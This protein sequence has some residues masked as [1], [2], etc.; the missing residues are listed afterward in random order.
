MV[1]SRRKIGFIAEDALGG[2]ISAIKGIVSLLDK[3]KYECHVAL[4]NYS[5]RKDMTTAEP[6]FTEIDIKPQMYSISD[7]TNKFYSLKKIAKDF[8]STVDLLVV[9]D[10]YELMATI[11]GRSSLPILMIVHGDSS[12][13]LDIVKK[14]GNII[15]GFACISSKIFTSVC[16]VLPPD[17]AF[18]VKI[19]RHAIPEIKYG[20]TNQFSEDFRILFIGRFNHY[21]GVEYLLDI[22]NRLGEL[23][24]PIT[25]SIVTNGVGQSE[26]KRKWLN[27]NTT[28]FYSNI[29][30]I[31]VQKI[32]SKCNVILMPSTG[33]G[34]PVALVEAMRMGCVPICSNISDGFPEVVT[35]GK[36][37]YLLDVKNIDSFVSTIKEL[38]HNRD[39]LNRMSEQAMIKINELFNPYTNIEVFTEMI[40]NIANHNSVKT[41]S[42]WKNDLGRLDRSFIPNWLIRI[43]R[44]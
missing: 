32:I 17:D 12:Y 14:Y 5:W 15:D 11:I 24:L 25:F 44:K 33:E 2:V 35:N 10:K 42:N 28:H 18:K 43:I 3:E 23:N 1:T 4:I 29:S 31:E 16:N 20:C 19:C 13:E 7:D 36:T 38:Y 30:N 26:F 41:I 22:G 37:G 39:V 21:K 8:I 9:G 6:S 34:L 27:N 40:E